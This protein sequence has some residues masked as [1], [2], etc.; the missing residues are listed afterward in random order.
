MSKV[1]YRGRDGVGRRDPNSRIKS[2]GMRAFSY[3]GLLHLA[4]L[5]SAGMTLVEALYFDEVSITTWAWSIAAIYGFFVF[6]I[7]IIYLLNKL[8][9]E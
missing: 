4:F 3:M 1:R 5:V 2:R 8:K 6:V 9:G 7:G